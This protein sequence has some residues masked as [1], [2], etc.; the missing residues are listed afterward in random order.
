MKKYLSILACILCCTGVFGQTTNTL[1]GRV[2]D[3][4]SSL[5]GATVLLKGTNTGTATDLQ[6]AFQLTNLPTGPATLVISY[7]GY[8]SQEMPV[9]IKAGLNDLTIIKLEAAKSTLGEVVVR[10]SSAGSQVKAISIKRASLGIMDVL[11]SDAI[12]KLPDRNAAE[13]VQRLPGVSIERDLGEG[14]YVSVRGTPIQWS[15]SLLNSNRMPSAS[16]DFSDRRLQMDIFPSELI[17]YV[18]LSKAITPDIEGDAIGGSINFV[19]RTAP[20]KRTLII[21]GAGGYNGLV[22][23]GSYNGSIIYGDRLLKNKLGFI[24]AT[25]I[26]NRGAGNNRYNLDYNFS[27]A[28]PTQAF[29]IADLQLRNYDTR[30]RTTGFNAGLEYVF[31]DRHKIFARGLY[32][33]Y[34]DEQRVRETYFNFDAKNAQVQT[35]HGFYNGQLQSI[36]LGGESAFSPNVK[37]TW[38]ASTDKAQFRFDNGG[39]PIATF[40][41]AA[42]Y[43]GLS[44]DGREYLQMD[45]PNGVGDVIDN[46][47]PHLEVPLDPTLLKLARVTL[48][49]SENS[50]VNQRVAANLAY[51]PTSKLNLKMGGKY[52]HKEKTVANAPLDV[53]APGLQ[54]VP[55][56]SIADL[57]Q[58]PY[59][60]KGDFLSAIGSPYT[61]VTVD[62]IS[63]SQVDG[64]VTPDFIAKYKLLKA[65]SDASNNASG[66]AKYYNGVENVYATYLMA[67]YKVGPAFTIL[68]GVRNEYNDVKFNSS[69]VLTKPVSA[70]QNVTTI[71]PLSQDNSYNAFLPMLHL[72]FRP[73]SKNVVRLAYTRTFIRPD[74][75]DLNPATTQSDITRVISQGNAALKPT[76]SSNFDLT[77]EHYFG[78]V[79]LVTVGG[80]YK[81]ITNYIY[82]NQSSQLV[83]GL[84]YLVTRPENLPNASLGGFEVA[85]SKRFTN[86]PGFW[87]GFGVEGNY[88][89]ISSSVKIPRRLADGSYTEDQSSLPKQA[90]NVFNAVLLYERKAFSARLAGN[91]KGKY[92]DAIRSAAG[93][94]HYRW[95]ASNFTVDFSSSYAVSSKL[96]VFLEVNNITNAPVR[97]YHGT[98]NRVEQAEWY[99]LRGQIGASLRLF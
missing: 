43:T 81:S 90:Q 35:R 7:I 73:D 2:T 75:S 87:R 32:N 79:G 89:F 3:A 92:V 47:Q 66:A 99:S 55:A 84:N 13:A 74:F 62:Q 91:Y 26:W 29:S 93:P 88:T 1:I 51:S 10:G 24:V 58:E 12:G 72:N 18:Q 25:S 86:L 97:F 6:G 42:K 64:T 69:L 5:P 31:N 19:T 44:S 11:A 65:V 48:I 70:T 56:P 77:A 61:A 30:R 40:Q 27:L 4:N 76:F 14:R 28:N 68:G 83:D 94:D 15:A 20:V 98:A 67:D 17:Q 71:T 36:E 78:G 63:M 46:V 37:F 21:N 23:N 22:K 54:G 41:Q 45:S 80:F 38:T 82:S 16:G 8:D 57:G 9:D 50:E 39:Y 85:F 60:S 49:R 95:Y 33:Q 59:P 34:L 96:R 53:Y 52:I